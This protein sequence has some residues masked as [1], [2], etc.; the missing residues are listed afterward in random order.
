MHEEHWATLLKLRKAEEETEGERI[1]SLHV[2]MHLLSNDLLSASR[3][4]RSAVTTLTMVLGRSDVVAR[5][6]EVEEKHKAM[7]K[8]LSSIERKARA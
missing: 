5:L 3:E 6:L 8:R 2:D 1:V 7:G 4:L